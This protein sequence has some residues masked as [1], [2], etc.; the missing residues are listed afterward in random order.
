MDGVVEDIKNEDVS[1]DGSPRCPYI[2]FEARACYKE[3]VPPIEGSR[4]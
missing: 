4:A 3:E 1:R 2:E